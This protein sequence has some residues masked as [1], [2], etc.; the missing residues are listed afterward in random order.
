MDKRECDT[1][2]HCARLRAAG[3]EAYLA[4]GCVRDRLLGVRPKDYDIATS[5][6]PDQIVALFRRTVP[7]GAAF[8]VIMVLAPTGPIEVATFRTD[9]PYCD[10]RRPESV[11]FTDARADARRRDFTINA[12]FLDPDTNEVIDYEGGREDLA[13]GIIR[14]VG[15]PARRFAED[16]LRML[17]AIRFAARL[18]YAIEPDTGA[19]IRA[20]APTVLSTSAERIRDE[21]AAMFTGPAPGRALR[22]LDEYGLLE[23]VLPEVADMKGVEQPPEFH[24]E[25][26]VFIH[27]G[28]VL[29]ALYAP[30]VTLA[31][32]ALLHDVGK[33]RTITYEDRIRFNGHDEVGAKM[34]EDICSRLKFSNAER[35]R[36]VWL[37]AM[38]MRVAVI[39]DMR[40]AKRKR[41]VRQDGFDELLAL[42]LA[43]CRGSHGDA[44]HIAWI[45]D[46]LEA[47]PPERARPARLIDGRRL[48]ALGYNPGPRFK[49]IL[50]A[51]EDAQLEGEVGTPEAAE[52]WLATRYPEQ[53]G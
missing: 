16:R 48:I 53:T 10:G 49:E 23:H 45:L 41:L 5:A 27:T 32:G 46:Y 15:E 34:A 4:G 47:L 7:V 50:D 2:E 8:G 51:L 20:L 21:L 6:T 1:R 24:P 25:G 39:P 44:D 31:F 17:R 35:E 26:D 30:T 40:E 12:M 9:G 42:G 3:Y 29:N 28:L 37:V 18:G 22:L 38:H 14:T 19:C 36:I 11:T 33:P 13:R 43:D 52:A